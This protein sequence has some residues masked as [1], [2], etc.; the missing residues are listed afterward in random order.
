MK[1][2]KNKNANAEMTVEA[3][4]AALTL[5]NVLP[6]E[7]TSL[8]VEH[9]ADGFVTDFAPSERQREL[10]RETFKPVNLKTLFSLSEARGPLEQLLIKQVLHYIEI[11]GLDAPGLFNL[12][13]E[14]GK[15][16][17]LRFVKAASIEEIRQKV[18]AL[19]SA[20]APL[21]DI[22]PVLTLVKAL[23][24]PFTF[25]ALANR[26]LRVALF[27]P[28]TDTLADGDEVLRWLIFKATDKTLL[29]KDDATIQ[30][31]EAFARE[32]NEALI[33]RVL[34]AHAGL[35]AQVFNR[36]KRLLIPLKKAGP[37]VAKLVNRIARLSKTAHVPFVT[38]P[39]K[40]VIARAMSGERVILKGIS[41]VDKFR[42]LNLIEYK[43]L[44]LKSDTFNI[45]NGK[46]WTEQNRDTLPQ[47]K[48]E[49][50]KHQ[51]LAS[52]KKDLAPLRK[53]HILLDEH[54]D[55]GLPVSRKQVVG[56]L[57]FGTTVRVV[58]DKKLSLGIYWRNEW[59]ARDLDLSA[60]ATNGQRVGWGHSDSY[61][62]DDLLFSGDVTNAPEGGCEFFTV[63]PEK[64]IKMGLIM[65]IFSGNESAECEII[66][67]YPSGGNQYGTKEVADSWQDRTLLRERV[68]LVSKQSF[69]GFLN[70][71][72]F[73]LYTGRM[74][75]Q[76]VSG[77]PQP[78]VERGLAE[79]WTLGRLFKEIGVKFDT[80]P[81]PGV[82][83]EHDLRY[84]SFSLDK[85][86]RVFEF[87]K[88]SSF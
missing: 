8:S 50:L 45:R 25:K 88:D 22:D 34:T 42:Y 83:Y 54:V 53:Q 38:P 28:K 55:Y 77:G 31:L 1:I 18:A 60:L 40:T 5:F 69:L 67:G 33:A 10:L 80:V 19:L 21:G 29:I 46:V 47:D 23:N 37:K 35:L 49:A 75:S 30:A 20:N 78:I 87:G 76:R 39:A 70:Q 62:R 48:L 71:D 82:H 51:V 16:T 65:N 36:H 27:N 15:T 6:A 9:A 11:Y 68:K 2:M 73:V 13:F 3:Q 12:E 43:L 79:F 56:N 72:R 74:G 66:V 44:G 41:V 17:V 32:G 61:G 86:E 7:A 85:L 81:A 58:K 63:N 84:G 4:R 64:D 52:L 14:G 59:G 24:V 26:E 57:P